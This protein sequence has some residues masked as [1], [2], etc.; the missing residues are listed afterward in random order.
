MVET[1]TPSEGTLV[2]SSFYYI[3]SVFRRRTYPFS[4]RR[5]YVYLL[6]FSIAP[7]VEIYFGVLNKSLST[8]Y[9]I[10]SKTRL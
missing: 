4:R 8:F 2:T 9:W 5:G 3:T 6:R 10:V 1:V 7:A